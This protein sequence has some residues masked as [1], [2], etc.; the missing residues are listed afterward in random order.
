LGSLQYRIGGKE[1][2]EADKGRFPVRQCVSASSTLLTALAGIVVLKENK[3]IVIFTRI[4]GVVE[5]GKAVLE[6]RRRSCR[7]H[8]Q[9]IQPSLSKRPCR[10]PKAAANRKRKSHENWAFL[11]GPWIAGA[12]SQLSMAVRPLQEKGIR[13]QEKRKIIDSN[14][15]ESE[16]NRRAIS[17]KKRSASFRAT[18]H[19]VSVYC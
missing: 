18:C 12:T 15:N 10:S 16:F 14:E 17:Y 19:K 5:C 13:P 3:S 4:N 11:T 9:H 2:L 7:N 8:T 6:Q 1:M